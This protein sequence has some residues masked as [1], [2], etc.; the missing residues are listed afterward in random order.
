MKKLFAQNKIKAQNSN[1]VNYNSLD[2]QKGSLYA[3]TLTQREAF[4][5]KDLCSFF[6]NY[7][8]DKKQLSNK[9]QKNI[10]KP[11]VYSIKINTTD[12]FL[13]ADEFVIIINNFKLIALNFCELCQL[14]PEDL[15]VNILSAMPGC[16]N[17]N[18]GFVNISGNEF[19]LAKLE[20]AKLDLTK[21][22]IEALTGNCAETYNN[23]TLELMKD[24]ITGY[25]SKK[26]PEECKE[27]K[28][29]DI[30]QSKEAKRIIYKTIQ[31]KNNFESVAFDGKL[32]LASEIDMII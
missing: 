26:M 16:F 18:F 9:T 27:L 4:S 25:F 13:A 19:N 7:F 6:K 29:I 32:V 11:L 1:S 2:Y 28:Y 12:D 17:I 24:C 5:F 31:N 15:Q 30:K 22:I 3:Y 8:Y 14:A 21:I 20:D 10:N 23:K